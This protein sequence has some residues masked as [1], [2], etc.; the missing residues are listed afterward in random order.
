[1]PPRGYA[2]FQGIIVSFSP[3]FSAAG[4]QKKAVFLTD[5]QKRAEGDIL[6][7]RDASQSN[8]SALMYNFHRFFQSLLFLGR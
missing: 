5:Y 6:S 2:I 4:Y 1:M 8:L 7:E 3:V